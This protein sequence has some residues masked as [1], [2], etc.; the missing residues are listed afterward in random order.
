MLCE[1]LQPILDLEID[2]GNKI[3]ETHR[4]AYERC[5]LLLELQKPFSRLHDRGAAEVTAD[6]NRDPHYPIGK[7]YYCT[8]H[9]QAIYAPL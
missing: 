8:I 3:R 9:R 1:H 5:E 2:G 6:V 7:S 4:D